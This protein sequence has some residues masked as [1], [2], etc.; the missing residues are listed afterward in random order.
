[1]DSDPSFFSY[2]MYVFDYLILSALDSF[3]VRKYT[4]V[5]IQGIRILASSK[6]LIHS[7]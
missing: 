4:R 1:M 2:P 6:F 5:V 7:Y 3:F